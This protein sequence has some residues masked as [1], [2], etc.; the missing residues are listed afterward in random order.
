MKK[1]NQTQI[2]IDHAWRYEDSMSVWL[3]KDTKLSRLYYAVRYRRRPATGK[4]GRPRS[5]R[6]TVELISQASYD[7]QEG[8]VLPLRKYM[9]KHGKQI[10]LTE[11]EKRRIAVLTSERPEV[12]TVDGLNNFLDFHKKQFSGSTPEEVLIKRMLEA[13][14]L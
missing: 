5:V 11:A 9:L 12:N 3:R 14:K 4:V 8:N 7:G 1:Q 13:E 10:R 2:M 6:T